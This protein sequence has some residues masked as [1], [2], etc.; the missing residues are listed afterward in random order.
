MRCMVCG[1]EMRLVGVVPDTSL[2]LAGYAH[3]SFECPACHDTETR[4]LFRSP[5]ES[6]PPQV[7]KPAVTGPGTGALSTSAPPTVPELGAPPQVPE[8]AATGPETGE[9]STNAPP[10]VPE[11]GAPPAEEPLQ[12]ASGWARA[13][14][15]LRLR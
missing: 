2:R 3:H 11:A 9:L 1:V 15:K 13:L 7:A 6:A 10:T 14:S 4:L 5:P 8:L 12:P